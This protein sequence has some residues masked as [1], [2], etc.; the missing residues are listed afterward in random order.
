[1]TGVKGFGAADAAAF[2]AAAAAASAYRRGVAKAA[3]GAGAEL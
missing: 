2:E 3:G 1:M